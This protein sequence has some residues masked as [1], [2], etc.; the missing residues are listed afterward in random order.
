MRSADIYYIHPMTIG[1]A[2]F[3]G[4]RMTHLFSSGQQL[5]VPKTRAIGKRQ[6]AMSNRSHDITKNTNI[7]N[8][9]QNANMHSIDNITNFKHDIANP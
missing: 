5:S 6:E 8:D 9:I 2:P 4:M 1:G 7:M 3:A